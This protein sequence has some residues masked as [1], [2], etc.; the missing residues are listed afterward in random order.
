MLISAVQQLLSY[1][2]IYILSHILFHYDLSQDIEYSSLCYTVGPYCLS[3][4]YILVEM[5]IF[6]S[7]TYCCCPRRGEQSR[8]SSPRHSRPCRQLSSPICHLMSY[9]HGLFPNKSGTSDAASLLATPSAQS[10][11]PPE[12]GTCHTHDPQH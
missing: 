9:R 10:A 11:L 4:L 12:N 7:V 8:L 2:Y 6:Y 5:Q 3:I 1:T